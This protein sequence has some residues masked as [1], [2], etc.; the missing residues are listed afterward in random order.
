MSVE[1]DRKR[2]SQSKMLQLLLRDIK[3][4]E[5]VDVYLSDRDDPHDYLIYCALIPTDKIEHS[6]S[7]PNWDL[8]IGNGMPG[9]VLHGQEGD[10]EVTYLRIGNEEGIEPLVIARNFHDIR[11]SYKE[12][13]EEF[14]L[15]HNLYHDR[16][17][18]QYI[19]IDDTGN[20]HVVAELEPE[21]ISIRLKEIRQFLAIKEMHL[22]IQFNTVEKSSFTLE[23]LGLKK[24][25]DKNREDL[26]IWN[27]HYDDCYL[28]GNYLA[29]SILHGKRLIT[30]LPKEKSGFWGFSEEEPKKYVEFIIGIDENGDEVFHSSNPELLANNFGSNPGAPLYLTPVHFRKQ[31]LDKYYQRPSKYSLEDDILRCGCLWNMDLDNHND[32]KV[33]AWLGDLG[34]DLPYEEQLHWRADN[35]PPTGDMS[36]TF[37]QRQIYAQFTAS[38]RPEH[39]FQSLYEELT[40]ACEE[41]LGF[42]L[43][44][45]LGADDMHHFQCL[46]VPSTDEQKDFDELILGLAKILIDSLNKKQLERLIPDDQKE[47]LKHSISYLEAAF[48][49]CGITE[50]E[51]HMV[52]LRRLQSLRSSGPAHRKGKKYRKIATKFGIDSQN[53]RSV[54]SGILRKATEFLKF[55]IDVV[56]SAK[57]ISSEFTPPKNAN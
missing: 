18:N 57:L 32:D 26:L 52:F 50:A 20:E 10:S 29:F 16:K 47:E 56:H 15:F 36:D 19:K 38:D 48:A 43:L 40:E 33:C 28:P 54:F 4:T 35:I 45:P 42:P 51:N 12:I 30:P 49:A 22:A 7:N 41:C 24:K 46:H 55:L 31:V 39:V 9:V 8:S 23:E 1:V 2:L 34:R 13:C 3:P 44:F 6:M 21:R 17:T 27:R 37:L 25:K 11:K 14:R 53:L 5:M